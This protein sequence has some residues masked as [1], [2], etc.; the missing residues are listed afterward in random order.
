MDGTSDISHADDCDEDEPNEHY[1]HEQI[2][3]QCPVIASMRGCGKVIHAVQVDIGCAQTTNLT[4]TIHPNTRQ[5][6]SNTLSSFVTSCITYA[7]MDVPIAQ[8]NKTKD[9]ELRKGHGC[10]NTWSKRLAFL[11]IVI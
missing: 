1:G 3:E 6:E 9:S 11:N 5:N 7:T 10:I 4:Y 8:K 2:G